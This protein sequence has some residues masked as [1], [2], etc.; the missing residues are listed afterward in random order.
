[1]QILFWLYITIFNQFSY[2][3]AFGHD[4]LLRGCTDEILYQI[5]FTDWI[6]SFKKIVSAAYL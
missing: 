1:M 4:S 2:D 3:K 5:Y 6:D